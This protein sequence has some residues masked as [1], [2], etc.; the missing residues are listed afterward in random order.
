M[1][2]D[3]RKQHR[4]GSC[5]MF[6]EPLK[7]LEFAVTVLA[8]G[9]PVHRVLHVLAFGYFGSGGFS[10]PMPWDRRMRGLQKATPHSGQ[11]IPGSPAGEKCRST[12]CVDWLLAATRA[13]CTVMN[14]GLSASGSVEMRFRRSVS[15]HWVANLEAGSR[16]CS[17]RGSGQG[18]S[19]GS[20]PR[21]PAC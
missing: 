6:L 20:R 11:G 19:E 21:A 8:V 3:R 12:V 13:C 18:K 10:N 16:C 15:R 4:T 7:T 9:H 14:Q 17:Q 1:T 5:N 2:C